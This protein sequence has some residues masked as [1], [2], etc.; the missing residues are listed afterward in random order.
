MRIRSAG[1][2]VVVVVGVR[3]PAHVPPPFADDDRPVGHEEDHEVVRHVQPKVGPDRLQPAH[4]ALN[5]FDILPDQR[6][7]AKPDFP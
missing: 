6:L 3:T 4:V 2:L 7:V 1:D 5:L